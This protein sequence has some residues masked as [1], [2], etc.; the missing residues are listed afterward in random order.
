MNAVSSERTALPRPAVRA[1]DVGPLVNA[2]HGSARPPLWL[3]AGLALL[4]L[5][6]LV[7]D[8]ARPAAPQVRQG[9]VV[10]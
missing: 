6:T 3:G 4:G 9:Q 5:L 10:G 7:P 8:L 1:D 2:I